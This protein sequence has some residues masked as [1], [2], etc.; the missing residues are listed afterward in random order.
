MLNKKIIMLAIVL[1]SLLAISAVSAAD[2]TTNDVVSVEDNDE[3]VVAN[4]DQ[5]NDLIEIE[6]QEKEIS[7]T[8]N[9][10]DVV[11]VEENIGE[12]FNNNEPIDKNSSIESTDNLDN[13]N[14][15]REILSSVGYYDEISF[16]D[17][18]GILSASPSHSAYSVSVA[19]YT[20]KY[21][22][23]TSIYIYITKFASS[24]MKYD[25]YFRIYNSNNVL[26][27][28]QRY[29]SS[30]TDV[31][32]KKYTV[33]SS[34]NPGIYTMKLI[35]YY[36]DYVMDTGKLTVEST[37]SSAYS[38]SV[39]DITIDYGSSGSIPISIS[40]ASYYDYYYTSD[41]YFKLYDSNGNEKISKRYYST[42]S[43]SEE[44][45]FISSNSLTKGVY[46][47]KIFNNY[48]NKLMCTAK[49][50]I[51]SPY[52]PYSAYSVS[53]SDTLMNYDDGGFIEMSITPAYSYTYKHDFYLKVYD[54]NGYEKISKRYYTTG[55]Y[56][57]QSYT[58]SARSFNPG[59]YTIMIKNSDDGQIMSTAKL[60]VTK[61]SLETQNV[62]ANCNEVFEYKV[63]AFENNNYKSGLNISITC[64]ENNYSV[65]TN[66]QGYATLNMHLKAGTYD[67][68][69]IL[70]NIIK[71]NTIVVNPVYVANVYKNVYIKSFTGYYNG[72]NIINYGWK[73]NLE[74]YFKIYKG[75]NLVYQN[76]FN[77][78][79][80]IYDYFTYTD[81][82]EQYEG[83]AI[84]KVGIYKA[85]ITDAHGNVLTKATIEIKKA[86]PK[87]SI[88]K[89]TFSVKLRTKKVKITLKD[90]SD[91]IKKV[92][93]TLKVKGKIYKAKTNSKGVALFKLKK[94]TKGT[95][96]V[97]VK[98]KGDKNYNKVSK[99][100]KIKVK[101]IKKTLSKKK[102]TSSSNK[103]SSGTYKFNVPHANAEVI[104][105]VYT[106]NNYNAYTTQTNWLGSGE[107]YVT[108]TSRTEHKVI[109]EV[110]Y[111]DDG[112]KTATYEGLSF[113][114]K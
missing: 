36:D 74:G 40:P 77:S 42:S 73:G 49:L 6:N 12:N 96:K 51:V 68:N 38:V 109:L 15:S 60:T 43:S 78:N 86:S 9:N 79:G 112:F 16:D 46:T 25:F 8:K 94:L 113:F 100:F 50:K 10:N 76:K 64:N 87:F 103:K 104:V 19:D 98:F 23:S 35:N 107:V 61:L 27:S 105:K 32:Y 93:L 84:K 101:K 62:S 41:F 20:V 57:S 3:T 4:E 70:G 34:L 13:L 82:D 88:S 30:D 58:I 28:S 53:V 52:P 33:S 26:V 110:H 31:T 99:K 75:N 54:S 48:D 17:Y 67:V 1:V 29:Y 85:V 55:F 22:F 83:V 111:Y 5:S 90:G 18:S 69:T 66:D 47:I 45:Y 106:G 114:L 108:E 72:K 102:T 37:P 91:G 21:G 11:S 39:S 44:S 65:I 59:I 95:Y 80:N 89:K 56:Y 92:K 24:S 63:R 14:D 97:T 71:K 2:N 81:H 7:A